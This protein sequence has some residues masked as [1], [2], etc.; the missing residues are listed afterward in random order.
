MLTVASRNLVSQP[1]AL[2]W[3]RLAVGSHPI[4]RS[5]HLHGDYYS[6]VSPLFYPS[7]VVG[8]VAPFTAS[9]QPRWF[10]VTLHDTSTPS[11][12]YVL[13]VRAWE[14]YNGYPFR[15]LPI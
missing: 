10:T 5:N 7:R 3:I 4:S 14:A 12:E 9:S 1:S 6:T 13:G 8:Q 15:I 11:S 2:Y